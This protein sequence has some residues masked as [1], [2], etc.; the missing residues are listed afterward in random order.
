MGAAAGGGQQPCGSKGWEEVLLQGE[1]AHDS[2]FGSAGQCQREGGGSAAGPE[3]GVV[4]VPLPLPRALRDSVRASVPSL[5]RYWDNGGL[6]APQAQQLQ[7]QPQQQP[8]QQASQSNSGGVKDL[9]GDDVTV[10][11]PHTMPA[12]HSM[13]GGGQES[14]TSPAR[15]GSGVSSKGRSSTERLPQ[16]MLLRGLDRRSGL[17]CD[18][19]VARD[20]L[21]ALEKTGLSGM[22]GYLRTARVPGMVSHTAA[23]TAVAPA[24]PPK[25]TPCTPPPSAQPSA[26]QM[27]GIHRSQ[28]GDDQPGQWASAEGSVPIDAGDSRG[29][30]Q[31][32]S[33]R[34]S[35]E[36]SSATQQGQQM[37]AGRVEAEKEDVLQM[38]GGWVPVAV[39]LGVPLYSLSLCKAVC[40]CA[41]E[42]G[43]LSQ[44]GREAQV[45]AQCMLQTALQDLISQFT[46]AVHGSSSSSSSALA[47]GGG[48]PAFAA[49]ALPTC[50][51]Y[52]DGTNLEV[53][54][55]QGSLQ[56]G[57]VS[58]CC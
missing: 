19:A 4:D 26:A 30:P 41:Q 12:S 44:E 11:I 35:P 15:K 36:L 27:P 42:Q 10:P 5:A 54:D 55:L 43:A 52:F 31:N 49:V 1:A 9:L 2:N 57:G 17:P 58:W 18:I 29:P 16:A 37:Q 3:G 53:V 20:V 22:V 46:V 48:A 25:L 38:G 50:N 7:Q 8:Q 14:K 21:V 34:Q 33:A 39:Q 13:P 24:P 32:L 23:A 56:R 40:K 6:H 47:P 28:G 51:L 45:L